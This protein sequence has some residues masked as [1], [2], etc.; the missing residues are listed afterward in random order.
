M[1]YDLLDS[2]ACHPKD[3]QDTQLQIGFQPQRIGPTP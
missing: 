2:R 3:V 1:T